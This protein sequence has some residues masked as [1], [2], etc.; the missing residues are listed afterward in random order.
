MC[1][2]W[3]TLLLVVFCWFFSVRG[4]AQTQVDTAG[5]P[6]VSNSFYQT[7]LRQAVQDIAFEADMNIVFGTDVIGTTDVTFTNMRV[8]EALRLVLAGSGATFEMIDN[9]ILIYEPSNMSVLAGETI[10]SELFQPR[11]FAPSEIVN[12]LPAEQREYTR[13]LNEAGLVSVVGPRLVVKNILAQMRQLD[14][15]DLQTAVLTPTTM[16]AEDVKAAL[17]LSLS[18]FV[19]VS[20]NKLIVRAPSD[21]IMKIQSYLRQ[22]DGTS[23]PMAQ[24]FQGQSVMTYSPSSYTPSELAALLPPEWREFIFVSP[25]TTV[26]TFVGEPA[27]IQTLINA[28]QTIDGTPQQIMINAKVVALRDA[29]LIDQGSELGLPTPRIGGSITGGLAGL[30]TRP[31]GADLG[32]STGEDFSN[33][34][35]VSLSMLEGNQNAL[36]MSAPTIMSLDN[37][38]A[39]IEFSTTYMSGSQPAPS[40]DE[41]A[42]NSIREV[43][44]GTRLQVIP[45]LLGNGNIQLEIDVS[46]SDYDEATEG[47]GAQKYN[48]RAKTT[49]VVED[50][51]TAVVGGLVTTKRADTFRGLPGLGNLFTRQ[52]SNDERLQVSVLIKPT[53][54][55]PIKEIT[56][57]R[58]LTHMDPQTYQQQLLNELK[59]LGAM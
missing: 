27:V 55:D 4:S 35:S 49:V 11:S 58:V 44:T 40:S 28:V 25:D 18:S 52:I 23:S 1:R 47:S 43:A 45:K 10:T 13:T 19:T 15:V 39:E 46:V 17:P 50:G 6:L 48:R 5:F 7:D 41:N 36:I 42:N 9:F 38:T 57:G 32:Y 30:L 34:L 59:R 3:S 29:N 31:W 22:L 56:E 37:K 33:A 21:T 14:A 26:M 53:I 20:Q 12:L 51:G 24:A 16:A 8:N 2:L 54:V